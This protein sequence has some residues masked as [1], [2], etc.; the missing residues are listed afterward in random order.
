MSNTTSRSRLGR[1]LLWGGGSA[2]LILA[3]VY[4]AAFFSSG[5]QQ[6]PKDIYHT[7]WE[8]VPGLA[9]D[10]PKDETWAPWAHK[11][12]QDIKTDE[13]AVRFTNEMLKTLDDPYTHLHSAEELKGVQEGMEGHFA[14]VG[15]S[16]AIHFG[17]DGKP[18]LD[19]KGIPM[20]KHDKDG[21]MIVAKLVEGGPAQKAGLKDNDVI[22]TADGKSLAGMNTDEVKTRMRGPVGTSVTLRISRDGIERTIV[23]KRDNVEVPPLKKKLL[24]G[25]IGYIHLYTFEQR[26][27]I[28]EL[29][30]AI[31]SMPTADAFIIDLRFNPGGLV[32]NAIDAVSLFVD[33]GVVVKLRERVPFGDYM[34][35]SF[36]L[37]KTELLKHDIDHKSGKVE[38]QHGKRMPNVVG[39]R[40]VIV[41][42]NEHSASASEMVTGA[43]QDLGRV[44]VVGMKTAG[45]GIGQQIFPMPNG[46]ALR[47]TNLKYFTPKGTWLG[48]GHKN[49]I[50]VTPNHV[51]KLIEGAKIGEPSDNQ[52]QF[53]IDLLLKK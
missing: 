33:E 29:S 16:L 40:P 14:G 49:T 9:Y 32:N 50:G 17:D 51:V 20:P 7:V 8:A 44:V 1:I 48:D 45:K 28:V 5:S 42:V 39:N 19:S 23:I 6:D 27:A 12:C 38:T 43:L 18:E 41:L 10:V 2:L 34:T 3:A 47:I 11:S 22:L 36:E 52:L 13:D 35:T 37:K 21:N 15:I 30:K 53:A 4:A 26:N 46:T 31:Q 24:D 25:N